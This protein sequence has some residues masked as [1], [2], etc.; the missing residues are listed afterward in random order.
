MKKEVYQFPLDLRTK[1]IENYTKAKLYRP[2]G[3]DML[4][5]HLICIGFTNHLLN[6]F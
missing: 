6:H 1:T 4:K 2:F 3:F 5:V